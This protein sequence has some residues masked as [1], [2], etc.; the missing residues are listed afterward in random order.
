MSTSEPSGQQP[1]HP[2]EPYSATERFE[3]V[4]SEVGLVGALTLRAFE[5]GTL[6][7]VGLLVCPPL[8]ILVVVVVVPL[9]AL[10]VLVSLIAAVLA[11]PYLIVRHVVGMARATQCCGTGSDV[12]S[13]RCWTSRHTACSPPSAGAISLG[14]RKRCANDVRPPTSRRSSSQPG[15]FSPPVH[16]GGQRGLAAES[17]A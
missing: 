13:T 7:L 17:V 16:L 2:N 11:T 10:T 1:L 8:F 9:V 3:E 6:V 12:R 4:G 5:V 15:V 14:D